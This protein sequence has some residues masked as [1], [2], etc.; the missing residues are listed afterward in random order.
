MAHIYSTKKISKHLLDELLQSIQSV[1]GW[2]SVEIFIQDFVVSQIT[3]KNI[4]K[5]NGVKIGILT[6]KN[7]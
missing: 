1:K 2:G 6:R 5:P 4:K 7:K 3:E